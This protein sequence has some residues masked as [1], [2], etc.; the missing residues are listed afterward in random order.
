MKVG[1]LAQVIPV[2]RY[3]GVGMAVKAW[4]TC[5]GQYGFHKPVWVGPILALLLEHRD[6]YW[7]ILVP[8]GGAVWV[9][10]YRVKGIE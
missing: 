5:P 10:H 9:E 8:D 2:T 3:P 6:V 1:D 7:R 4:D